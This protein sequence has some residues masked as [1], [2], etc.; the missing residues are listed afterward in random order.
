VLSDLRESGYVEVRETGDRGRAYG[1]GE[2]ED[3]GKAE[4]SLPEVATG[5]NE[6]PTMNSY[7]WDFVLG[8]PEAAR[9]GPPPADR[10]TI[11]AST[12]AT[13]AASGA[14]PPG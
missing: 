10:P 9:G 14:G 4:V 12:A 1:Y 6:I 8:D 11:P 2:V 13:P 3:P 7:S 5:E